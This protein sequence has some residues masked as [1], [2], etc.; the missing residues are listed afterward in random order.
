[1]KSADT[2]KNESIDRK[3]FQLMML[4]QLKLEMIQYEKNFDDLRRLFKECDTDHS[5][6]LNK[7]ELRGALLKL[8]IV[9]SEV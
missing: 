8:G 2:D 5:N 1:M 6:Y 3:E 7:D 9:L 4:P